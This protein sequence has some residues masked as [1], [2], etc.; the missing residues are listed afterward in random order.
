MQNAWYSAKADEIQGYA[1]SNNTKRFYDSLKAAH[2][3]LPPSQS[4]RDPAANR[5][6]ADDGE[7][8]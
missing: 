4:R 7:M 8:D 2:R 6:E 1:D 5:E 3:L